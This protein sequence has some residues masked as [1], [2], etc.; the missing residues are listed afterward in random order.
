LR[1]PDF[2]PFAIYPILLLRDQ[3]R[4]DRT[5][6]YGGCAVTDADTDEKEK[7]QTDKRQTD[8]EGEVLIGTFAAPFPVFKYPPDN[9]P[10]PYCHFRDLAVEIYS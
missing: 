5:P 9:F 10:H 1:I 8:E 4:T 2:H 6:P 7:R 3:R